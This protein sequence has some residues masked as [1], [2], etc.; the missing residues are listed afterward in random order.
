[1]LSQAK[2]E[3]YAKETAWLYDHSKNPHFGVPR[4]SDGKPYEAKEWRARHKAERF[5]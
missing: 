3:K 5:A 1:M 4:D 2:A